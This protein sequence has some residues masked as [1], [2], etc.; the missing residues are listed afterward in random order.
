YSYESTGEV[1]INNKTEGYEI[2]RSVDKVS[3]IRT[4]KLLGKDTSYLLTPYGIFKTPESYMTSRCSRINK[5]KY[6]PINKSI[7]A[8]VFNKE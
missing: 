7:D 2:Y 3:N 4:G 8:W 1:W 5:F 6:L